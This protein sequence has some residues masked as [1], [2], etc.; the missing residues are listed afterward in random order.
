MFKEQNEA[1]SD[2][3]NLL[4]KL[5]AIQEKRQLEGRYTEALVSQRDNM[6]AII[7]NSQEEIEELK[8]TNQE[9]GRELAGVNGTYASLG[10]EF[11]LKDRNA[12]TFRQDL[13]K[14]EQF[15]GLGKEFQIR[16]GGGNVAVSKMRKELGA[17]RQYSNL[18]KE[19]AGQTRRVG[20][21]AST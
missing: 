1:V 7:E 9:L 13:F 19:E 18:A 4:K 6:N 21:P 12:S 2:Y 20:S 15:A 10:E 11:R 8:R 14:A 17:A 5:D 3:D 16:G